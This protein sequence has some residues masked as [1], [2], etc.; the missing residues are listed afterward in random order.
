MSLKKPFHGLKHLVRKKIGITSFQKILIS[1]YPSLTKN[2]NSIIEC[3]KHLAKQ[4]AAQ[5]NEV[6]PGNK[7]LLYG[8]YQQLIRFIRA[9]AYESIE[10]KKTIMRNRDY[11]KQLIR[12]GS[13]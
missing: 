9:C 5:L 7:L 13:I 4:A 1:N 2:I 12:I 3:I 10:W 8:W 6:D 11:S